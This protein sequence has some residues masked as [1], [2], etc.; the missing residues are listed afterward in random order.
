MR[1]GLRSVS[2]RLANALVNIPVAGLDAR[3]M[4][5]GKQ[6]TASISVPNVLMTSGW[7]LELRY[8]LRIIQSAG[9]TTRRSSHT[10][11]KVIASAPCR[12]VLPP[13]GRPCSG[14]PGQT[15][16]AVLRSAQWPY[17]GYLCRVGSPL[18]RPDL[19]VA[20][21][22]TEFHKQP[23]ITSLRDPPEEW[24]FGYS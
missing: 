23:S 8:E 9:G 2:D 11:S 1:P 24:I 6:K 4:V 7:A 5:P 14:G 12:L 19:L 16:S 13:K 15:V 18:D 22:C 17:P 21:E 3:K 10:C 20:L